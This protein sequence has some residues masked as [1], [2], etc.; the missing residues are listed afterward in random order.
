LDNKRFPWWL[1]H[2]CLRAHHMS[3][4]S[5]K[6]AQLIVRH[7]LKTVAKLVE[8]EGFQLNLL[9][10]VLNLAA[11]PAIGATRSKESARSLRLPASGAD[12]PA[13]NTQFFATVDYARSSGKAQVYRTDSERCQFDD[14][15]PDGAGGGL[16][17]KTSRRRMSAQGV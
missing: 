3:C 15:I 4:R 17:P 9:H 12:S 5:A 10:N 7:L 6:L 2:I 11:H 14:A 16:V 13:T 1:A 8:I